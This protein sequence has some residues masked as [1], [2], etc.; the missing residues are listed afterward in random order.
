MKERILKTGANHF[1]RRSSARLRTCWRSGST[2]IHTVHQLHQVVRLISLPLTDK[3]HSLITAQVPST[4][5]T[6]QP[7]SLLVSH[8]PTTQ[9]QQQLTES[10]TFQGVYQDVIKGR[11][12]AEELHPALLYIKL[13]G[14]SQADR[15]CIIFAFRSVNWSDGLLATINCGTVHVTSVQVW[16]REWYCSTILRDLSPWHSSHNVSIAI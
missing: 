1:V 15:I 9:V 11:I 8:Q 4:S 12:W 10:S 3:A 6:F 2:Q 5:A 16:R 7:L 14:L 13:E